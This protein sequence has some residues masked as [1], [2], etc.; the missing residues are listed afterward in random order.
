[1]EKRTVGVFAV[2]ILLYSVV[3]LRLYAL[4]ENPGLVAAA[5]EQSSYTLEVSRTRG[6]IYDRNLVRLTD[7]VEENWLA[8][9]PSDRSIQA[10]AQ[11]VTGTARQQVLS[12]MEQRRP[13]LASVGQQKVYAP[14]VENVTRRA[15]YEDPALAPH[16]LGYLDGEGEGVCGIEAAYNSL[17]QS[18][19]ERM[20]LTYRVDGMGRAMEDAPQRQGSDQLPAQGVVLTLDREI[21]QVVE[22]A[23][24]DID[25]GAAVVMDVQTG[26]I[27]AAVSRPS[28]DPEDV[29]A[30]LQ[31][32]DSP[33]YNRIFS[34]FNVGSTFKLAVAAAALEQG[35]SPEFS[36]ECVG[37]VEVDGRVFY[38]SNRAGHQHTDLRRA[39]EQSCNPYFIALGQQVGGENILAMARALGFGQGVT[40]AQGM[41][42]AAG[43]LPDASQIAGLQGLANFSFGQGSLT[44]TPLQIAAMVSTFANGGTAVTPTLVRGTTTDGQ[45]LEPVEPLA[46]R[47]VLSQETAAQIRECMIGVVTDGSGTPGN[48]SA[49]GAGGKTASAQTGIWEDGE[50]IVHAWFAGF[51]PA[52]EP[53]YAAVVLVEGGEYG[54]KIASP[55][56][57]QIADGVNL[58]SQAEGSASA[59]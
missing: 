28:F 46:G 55:I 44:A 6:G 36:V 21:Q 18:A 25:K 14:Y 26:K 12:Q 34:A 41:E 37:A 35:I 38:C 51:F 2:V 24:Q 50:E 20:T 15:R 17:L 22:R 47:R 16:L 30:S 49:G 54:G 39:I 42:S 5:Q 4:S 7:T 1:M 58:L 8:V 48:P 23:T 29:A 32:P 40:L 56:F 31:D 45:T 19:G 33:L 10:V 13:F 3:M 11:Q 52:Q 59:N 43:S 57:R 53:R 27:L 9:L